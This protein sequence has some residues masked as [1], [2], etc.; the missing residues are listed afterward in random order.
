M[1]EISMKAAL[2]NAKERGIIRFAPS[3]P[4]FAI[5]T[6]PIPISGAF[7]V[8]PLNKGF[9]ADIAGKLT[10]NGAGRIVFNVGTADLEVSST[11]KL[12]FELYKNGNPTGMMTPHSFQA[13]ANTEPM[14]INGFFE[15]ITGDYFEVYIYTDAGSTNV[16]IHTLYVSIQS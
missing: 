14:A 13:L 12:Y 10:Y 9:T 11:I 16:T 8:D 15:A 6:T 2:E 1:E 5:T 7:V 4:A 3:Q